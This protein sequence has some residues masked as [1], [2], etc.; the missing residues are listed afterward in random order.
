MWSDVIGGCIYGK[1]DETLTLSTGSSLA[2]CKR[3]CEIVTDFEC[4][5]IDYLDGQKKCYLSK[6]NRQSAGTSYQEQ[7]QSEGNYVYSEITQG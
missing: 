4:K 3:A 6:D 1:N 7:C 5:S 2:D